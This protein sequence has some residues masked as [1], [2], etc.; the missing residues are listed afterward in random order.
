MEY[1]PPHK[2]KDNIYKMIFEESELFIDFLEN[3]VSINILKNLSPDNIENISTRHLPLFTDNMDSDTIKKIT[4]NEHENIFVISVLEHES[5]VNYTSSF[6][7]L[8]YITYIISEYVKENDAKYHRE[9]D[10]YGS[11]NLKLST[12]KDFKYPPIF[13][14]V[15][16]DGTDEWTSETNFFDKTDMNGIFEKYIPKFEYELVNLNDYSQND[17]VT[18]NNALSLLLIIDKVKKAEDIKKLKDLPEKFIEEMSKKVPEVF[19]KIFRDS[20]EL[21]LKRINVP[22]E[23]ISKITNQIYERRF[24]NMFEIIDGYDVQATRREAREEAKEEARKEYE[25]KEKEYEKEIKKLQEKIKELETK[26]T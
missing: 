22:I 16:Y 10:K 13:P 9:L 17:L 18:F 8:Q 19:L 3:F 21:L 4:I 15:F 24:N 20:I 25:V 1:K 14:I 2:V 23:E 5:K 12:W 11:S 7:L 26:R 6:K